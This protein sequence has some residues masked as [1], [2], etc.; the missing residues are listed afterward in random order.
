MVQ[1]L[2]ATTHGI[3]KAFD[4]SP[5]LELQGVF[6]DISKVFDEVWHDGLLYRFKRNGINRDLWNLIESVL[7]E[8]YQRVVLNGQSF[9][10][11]KITARVH[12][13]SLLVALFFLIYI[14]DLPPELCCSPKNYFL[15]THPYFQA[16]KMSTKLL[17]N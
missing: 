1:Q 7:L 5:S 2:T 14:K 12:Q 17:K 15:M 3:Y 8:R 4:C 13:G 10:W 11:N 6:L 9:K 16:L